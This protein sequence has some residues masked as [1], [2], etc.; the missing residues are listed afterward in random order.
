VGRDDASDDERADPVDRLQERYAA[1]EISEAEFERR[2]ETVLQ[3]DD[4]EVAEL[5]V[6]E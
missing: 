5:I 6:E 2:M 3:T 1:D 4:E